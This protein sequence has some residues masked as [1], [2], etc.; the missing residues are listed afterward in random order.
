MNFLCWL[1]LAWLWK[2]GRDGG[3]KRR[4]CGKNKETW[5]PFALE[6]IEGGVR[7]TPCDYYRRG[8]YIE[9]HGWAKKHN[10][11]GTGES[12]PH[13]QRNIRST[14]RIPFH[15]GLISAFG[16]SRTDRPPHTDTHILEKRTH[17]NPITGPHALQ[18]TLNTLSV[19]DS[20]LNQW[21][22]G[23]FSSAFRF[24]PFNRLTV[25]YDK[26]YLLWI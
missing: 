8:H 12:R 11:A 1:C 24:K 19:W 23:L 13:R 17:I 14:V 18:W 22:M 3:G 16:R 15:W 21:N 26:G 4:H 2:E 9:K 7:H 10:K 20:D 5:T 6:K 25:I